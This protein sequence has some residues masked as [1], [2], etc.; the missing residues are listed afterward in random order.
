MPKNTIL[1]YFSPK[2]SAGAVGA[3]GDQGPKSK[4]EEDKD[5]SSR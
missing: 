5:V 3:G 2:S 1:N 4:S